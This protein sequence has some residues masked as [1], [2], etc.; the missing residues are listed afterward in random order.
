MRHS[1]SI[2]HILATLSIFEVQLSD[3]EH[4]EQSRGDQ[5]LLKNLLNT[6]KFTQGERGLVEIKV[7]KRKPCWIHSLSFQL[8]N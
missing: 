8:G 1:T 3:Q 7:R 5:P 6:L 4:K 2:L